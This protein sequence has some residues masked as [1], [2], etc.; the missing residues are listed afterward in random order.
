MAHAHPQA[1]KKLHNIANAY[2]LSIGGMDSLIDEAKAHSMNA[3]RTLVMGL[4]FYAFNHA[5]DAYALRNDIVRHLAL[6]DKYGVAR[7]ELPKALRD[8]AEKALVLEVAI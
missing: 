3:K 7:S 8:R 4:M 2:K 5:A 6:C 1:S